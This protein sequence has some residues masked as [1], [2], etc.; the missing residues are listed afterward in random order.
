MVPN[1]LNE[2][3]NYSKKLP[4]QYSTI[5]NLL[6]VEINK[7]LKKSSSRIYYSMP[8]WFIDENP[9]VSYKATPKSV[10]V[11]FWS[12]QDFKESELTPLGKFKAAQI[13]Y[14]SPSEVDVIKLRRWLKKSMKHIWDYKN[15]R[16]GLKKIK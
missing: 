1:Q 4:K 10:N 13:K 12:G 14:A 8:V 3:S 5:C 2:V 11:M 15:I 7:N 6:Q 9:I 16:T